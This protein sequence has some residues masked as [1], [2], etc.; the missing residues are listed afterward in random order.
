MEK[1]TAKAAMDLA[2]TAKKVV[3]DEES[4]VKVE[5]GEI[6]AENMKVTIIINFINPTTGQVETIKAVLPKD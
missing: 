4:D 5:I 3:G 1:L 6:N 2:E